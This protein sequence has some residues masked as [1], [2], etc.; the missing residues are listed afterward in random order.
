MTADSLAILRGPTRCVIRCSKPKFDRDSEDEYGVVFVRQV[1]HHLSGDYTK[2]FLLGSIIGKYTFIVFDY[3]NPDHLDTC[4][5]LGFRVSKSIRP[6]SVPGEIIHSKVRSW[7][8]K[9][10][11]Y[12][13]SFPYLGQVCSKFVYPKPYPWDSVTDLSRP[14]VNNTN[15][16]PSHSPFSQCANSRRQHRKKSAQRFG[17]SL[18]A[19]NLV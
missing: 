9:N 8:Q 5:V 13:L 18:I 4:D 15:E 19:E 11:L 17:N 2:A 1:V 12:K 10:E 14:K 7:K 16:T 6:I 3:D